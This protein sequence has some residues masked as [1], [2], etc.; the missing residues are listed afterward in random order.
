M[1][2]LQAIE[3]PQLNTTNILQILDFL[4]VDAIDEEN[5]GANNDITVEE[6]DITVIDN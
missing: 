1:V 5:G 2:Q 4:W 6:E 3:E